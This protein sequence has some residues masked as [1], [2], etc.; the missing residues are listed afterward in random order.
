LYQIGFWDDEGFYFNRQGYDLHGGYYDDNF[1]YVPGDDYDSKNECDYSDS[2]NNSY[3]DKNYDIYCDEGDFDD[4]FGDID[5]EFDDD[6]DK[7][8]KTSNNNKFK[9]ETYKEIKEV[10]NNKEIQNDKKSNNFQNV[11]SKKTENKIEVKEKKENK[12]NNLFG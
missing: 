4:E 7:N 2:Y 12:L 6:F 3:K 8:Y 5:G 11:E 1:I 9:I 10:D